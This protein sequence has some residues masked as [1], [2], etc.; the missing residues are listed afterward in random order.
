MQQA[1]KY[2]WKVPKTPYYSRFVT[3]LQPLP[4]KEETKNVQISIMIKNAKHCQP[5]AT[6]YEQR[7]ILHRLA[8]MG[9]AALAAAVAVPM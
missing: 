9:S 6:D 2:S 7:K 1:H 4:H 3:A 8:I 5:C